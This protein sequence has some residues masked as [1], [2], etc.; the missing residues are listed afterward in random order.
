MASIETE[1]NRPAVP[2][3]GARI[4]AEVDVEPGEQGDG[5]VERHIALCIDT[6]GSMNGAK[7][8]QARDGASWVFG[9]LEPAD[10]VSIVAFDSSA[11]VLLGPVQWGDL[12][13]DDALEQVEALSAGGGTDM[14]AGLETARDSLLSLDHDPGAGADAVRRLLLLSDGKDKDH[15]VAEFEGLAD[16][17]DAS[18]V[19][20]EAA[21][22]GQDYNQDTIRTLGTTARGKWTHLDAAGDIES[23]FGEAVESASAVVAAD[24][25]LE[26][27]AA[28]GVEVSDVYRALPQAQDVELEW[29]ANAATVKLPDLT[30]RERQRVV[31]KVAAPAHDPAERVPLVQVRL[32][33]RGDEAT[34]RIAVDYTEETE[35]LAEANEAVQ[36]D[37]QETVVRAELG[38]GNVEAAETQVE[39]MTQVHGETEVV[40]DIARETQVVKEG[41]KAERS[42]A[43]KLVDEE[44]VE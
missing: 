4:T 1:T 29:D 40:E 27:D 11:E 10:F 7:I 31:M 8:S 44:R 19:R 15:T 12:D 39:Q 16:D 5:G 38:K 2:P 22:I 9:L 20:I 32:R 13:R 18:G 14:Y 30:E 3:E 33:A 28:D 34:D 43:T 24:A 21:G 35:E 17:I 37:H 23:F 36:L 42:R 25:E 26:L 6:S 41:G